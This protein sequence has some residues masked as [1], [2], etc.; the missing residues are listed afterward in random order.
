MIEAYFAQVEQALQAFP[1]IRSY[2]LRKKVYNSKQGYIS[3]SIILESGHCLDFAE[4]KNS[5]VSSKIKYRYHYMDENQ[6][7][8]FR[9]DNAPHHGE[10]P[11]F[12]HH[13]HTPDGVQ[14]STEPEL[15]DILLEIAQMG[16]ESM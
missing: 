9:Y 4:V 12:P 8:I 15:Y 11:T 6:V 10:V 1:S 7:M 5:E 13:K 2:T 16:R 14:G 3:G